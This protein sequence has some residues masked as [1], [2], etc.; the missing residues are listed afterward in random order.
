M[1]TANGT[2]DAAAMKAVFPEALKTLAQADPEVAAI[3]ED[4]KRRQW[5]VAAARCL[6]QLRC[7][8][9]NPARGWQGL[10]EAGSTSRVPLNAVLALPRVSVD[11]CPLTGI[12]WVP[13]PL[14]QPPQ[15]A[16]A[17]L[18]PLFCAPG[19]ASS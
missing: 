5:C 10:R 2:H 17:A 9:A 4:E 6:L 1:T 7:C 15:P 13:L 14:V 19:A 11:G 18:A 3:I 16:R 8:V 12:R